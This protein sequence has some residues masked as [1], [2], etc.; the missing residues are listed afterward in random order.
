M[1]TIKR[2]VIQCLKCGDIIESLH[3]H[4]FK[5]CSCGAVSVDGGKNYLKRCF[6]AGVA[7]QDYKELSEWEGECLYE[8][9]DD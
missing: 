3:V 1:R 9:M 2:N 4:D 8:G 6:E 7:G 5:T